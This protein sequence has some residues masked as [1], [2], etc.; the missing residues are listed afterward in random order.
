MQRDKKAK[1]DWSS[2]SSSSSEE[3]SISDSPEKQKEKKIKLTKKRKTDVNGKS[4]KT[5]RIIYKK[6]KS[7][8]S[9][10]LSEITGFLFGG[11]SSRFWMLRKHINNFKVVQGARVKLPF[12]SWQCLS[13]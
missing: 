7:K 12:Y 1:E 8:A 5:E 11:M 13:L 2:S 6:S 4:I 9:C 3:N 10:D